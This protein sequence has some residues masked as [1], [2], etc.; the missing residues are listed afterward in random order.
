MAK[1]DWITWNTDTKEIINPDNTVEKLLETYQ[2]YNN[3]IHSHIYE[4]MKQEIQIGGLDKT[5]LNLYGESPTNEKA[6]RIINRIDEISLIFNRLIDSIKKTTEEQKRIEKEE[7]IQAIE[8]RITE[9]KKILENTELLKQK[10]MVS[11]QTIS[12]EEVEDIITTS[13]DKIKRLEERLELAKS[14]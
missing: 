1:V 6:I 12:I 14:I 10:I 7:L 4:S 5:S 2:N 13:K 11:N 9:E 3:F 8:K